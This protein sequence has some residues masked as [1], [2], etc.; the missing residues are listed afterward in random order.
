MTEAAPWRA[1]IRKRICSPLKPVTL[2]CLSRCR[3]RRP[4]R[5]SARQLRRMSICVKSLQNV[6]LYGMI[7]D[8]GTPI[9][10]FVNDEKQ[11]NYAIVVPYPPP[12][13]W[14]AICYHDGLSSYRPDELVSPYKPITY[15]AVHCQRVHWRKKF[16]E[17]WMYTGICQKCGKQHTAQTE[18]RHNAEYEQW[19]RDRWRWWHEELKENVSLAR[20]NSIDRMGRD[21][22]MWFSPNEWGDEFGNP[23]SIH[24]EAA[25]QSWCHSN[26]MSFQYDED[27][28]TYYFKKST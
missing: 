22:R 11:T 27:I 3:E 17:W 10:R 6:K 12:Y 23:L 18:I 7:G 8:M 13:T 14:D 25:L 1:T 2:R 4:K 16:H 21:V 9:S 5:K 20:N 15:E 24:T 26:G 19:M 28:D